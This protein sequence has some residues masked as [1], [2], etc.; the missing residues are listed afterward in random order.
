MSEE[1]KK[2]PGFQVKDRR[3][4]TEQGEHREGVSET[5]GNPQASGAAE[6]GGRQAHADSNQEGHR[7]RGEMRE[8]SAPLPE[9]DFSTFVFSLSSSVV[10]HLGLAPDPISGEMKRELGLAK[11][12]IDILGM[13][14]EKT[15]GNLNEEEKSLM[16]GILYDLRM[17]YVEEA[18][19][20]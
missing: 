12:T 16:E 5:E 6:G 7:A 2:G 20:K 17:R 19:K 18:K 1:E 9:I 15:R 14:Q 3:R 4:F 10:I 13:I 11:Q 8:P